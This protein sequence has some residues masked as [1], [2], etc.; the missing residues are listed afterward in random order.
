MGSGGGVVEEQ[1]QWRQL[2]KVKPI[3]IFL[4]IIFS[5]FACAEWTQEDRRIEAEQA[6]LW[7]V[8][9]YEIKQIP[10]AERPRELWL[11][12]RNMGHRRSQDGHSQVIGSIYEKL[13][14]E[15]LSCPRH[16]QY[17]ADEI[18]RLRLEG[19][20]LATA[21]HQYIVGVMANLPSPETLWVLGRY[22]NDERDTPPPPLPYQ[23]WT[24]LPANCFLAVDAL[25]K[26]GLRNAPPTKLYIFQD[27]E[28]LDENREWWRE[29]E[30]GRKT[31]SFRGQSVEYRFKPDGTWDTTPIANPP[32]D[33]PQ[34]ATETTSVRPIKKTAPAHLGDPE[35][36]PDF[37]WWWYGIAGFVVLVLG[38]WRVA[39]TF[40]SKD[41]R[42]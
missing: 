40:K 35:A 34:S 29:I 13:Q 1:T 12:L 30:S 42:V 9:L 8:K 17:F 24:A 33:G 28:V 7:E 38:A 16:A 32:D 41:R 11:G 21:R 14:A 3:L 19:K 26:I 36:S 15:L 23:D 6:A 4:H 39:V 37:S 5:A 22:L 2:V 10:A 25:G 31:F 20:Y 27:R 18:E